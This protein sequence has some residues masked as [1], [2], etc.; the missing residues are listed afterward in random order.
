[1]KFPII[2]QNSR[3][4][5]LLSIFIDIW[6]I[7]IWPFIICRGEM[8]EQTLNHEK[9]HIKQQAELLLIGFYLLY[10]GF[11]LYNRL[12]RRMSNQEAY[13]NIPFENEAYSND[14]NLEYLEER[15]WFAWLSYCK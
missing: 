1:M 10:A 14:S 15:K 12:W 8:N 6:A 3:I 11:W 9:I 13:M 2:I 4:P 5:K 7:T